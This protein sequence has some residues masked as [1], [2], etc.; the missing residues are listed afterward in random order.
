MTTLRVRPTRHRNDSA[1]DRPRTD[2]TAVLAAIADGA[3]RLAIGA[4]RLTASALRGHT[5]SIGDDEPASAGGDVPL[6]P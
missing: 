1:T 2:W 4:S 6:V 5:S 3:L